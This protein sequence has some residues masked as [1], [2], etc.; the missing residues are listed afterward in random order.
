MLH[1]TLKSQGGAVA[2]HGHSTAQT[3]KLL[4]G[5]AGYFNR[6]DLGWVHGHHEMNYRKKSLGWAAYSKENMDPFA[7][8]AN[9]TPFRHMETSTPG[10][11][12]AAGHLGIFHWGWLRWPLWSKTIL[13]MVVPFPFSYFAY[14][15]RYA[16]G[17]YVQKN[18]G[19]VFG[20]S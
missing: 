13:Y 19:A 3:K 16:K 1:R 14:R 15:F 18:V 9:K 11:W 12:F 7:P 5:A 8:F 2:H 20:A 6:T 10:L 17:G 4:P